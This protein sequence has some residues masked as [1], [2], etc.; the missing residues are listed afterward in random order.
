[1][2]QETNDTNP[3]ARMV[4]L[5][6]KKKVGKST[7]LG[8]DLSTSL[9]VEDKGAVSTTVDTLL[10]MTISRPTMAPSNV[11]AFTERMETW[12][13]NG[14]LDRYPGGVGV[15][16]ASILFD[17]SVIEWGDSKAGQANDFHKYKELDYWLKRMRRVFR[18]GSRNRPMVLCFH[19][20]SPVVV[21][22]ITLQQG[23]AE[24]PSKKQRGQIPAL[25]DAMLFVVDWP[26]SPD[27]V[28]KKGLYGAAGDTTWMTADRW[29][30]CTPGRPVIPFNLREYLRQTGWD[31]GRPKGLEWIDEAV[32]S[33]VSEWGKVE[34]LQRNATSQAYVQWLQAKNIHPGLIYWIMRDAYARR[35]Y[36]DHQTSALSMLLSGIA[37]TLPTRPGGVPGTGG[38]A[39]PPPVAGTPAAPPA[40][41]GDPAP[42]SSPA[43]A[44][45]PNPRG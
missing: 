19:E 35:W 10:Q 7:A 30:V 37:G 32:D 31:P 9:M 33:V 23:G 24:V 4:A 39:P 26:E 29:N 5:V 45:A 3:R 16:D 27:P 42:S 12:D 34:I 44:A 1:M 28:W 36:V 20:A 38:T 43:A 21:N 2:K 11:A 25:C 22:G 6:G 41:G 8:L 15:D 40:G 17:D 13:R 18:D 14:I